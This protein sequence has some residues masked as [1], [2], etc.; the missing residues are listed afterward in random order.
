MSILSSCTSELS[1]DGGGSFPPS[2]E[3]IPKLVITLVV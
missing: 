1:M 2:K 3:L